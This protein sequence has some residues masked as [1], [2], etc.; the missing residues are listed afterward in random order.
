MEEIRIVPPGEAHCAEA[1]AFRRAFAE[2]GEEMYG[3]GGFGNGSRPFA[4]WLERIRRDSCPATVRSGHVPASTYFAVRERDGKIVGMIQL[5]HYL[6]D[7]LLREGGHVGYCVHPQERRKGY[8]KQM[9]MHVLAKARAMGMGRVLI[10]C[11]KGNIASAH[12]ALSCGGVPEGDAA[13]GEDVPQRYW[14]GL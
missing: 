3:T 4:E 2:A 6:N 14:I 7:R 1:L 5:R 9:L 12:T 13:G 10:T 11:D 8:A